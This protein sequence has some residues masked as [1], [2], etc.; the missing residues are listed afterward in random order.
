MFWI[1]ILILFI[2]SVF[3]LLL[4]PVILHIDTDMNQYYVQLRGLAKA[5]FE[6]DE[7]EVIRIRLKVLFMDFLFYPLRKP[8]P[9]KKKIAGSR[10]KKRK[11]SMGYGKGLRL[12]RS[13]SVKR[14]LLDIDTG[15]CIHNAKLYPLFAFLNYYVGGF[16][17]NFS[18]RNQL[19]LHLQNRPLYIIKSIIN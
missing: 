2:S 6:G 17:V 4:I 15:D 7:E 19:V 3:Y 14:L 16:H 12:L 5:S 13:F 8:D 9:G 18:G 10:I 1:V 11:K